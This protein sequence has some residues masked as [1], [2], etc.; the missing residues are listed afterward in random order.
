M[1]VIKNENNTNAKPLS[2]FNTVALM[3]DRQRELEKFSAQLDRYTPPQSIQKAEAFKKTLIKNGPALDKFINILPLPTELQSASSVMLAF[4]GTSAGKRTVYVNY[5]KLA[6]ACI[7]L[8]SVF[9]Y[10]CSSNG[11]E[12]IRKM[13][14]PFDLSFVRVFFD[15]IKHAIYYLS[16]FFINIFPITTQANIEVT[17]NNIMIARS[18]L[19]FGIHAMADLFDAMGRRSSLKQKSK[20]L[21]QDLITTASVV[22]GELMLSL[23]FASFSS[24]FL[25]LFFTGNNY[26]IPKI[27]LDAFD[28]VT[29]LED[30]YIKYE[31]QF[32]GV[33]Y[34]LVCLQIM[35]NPFKGTPSTTPKDMIVN[36]ALAAFQNINYVVLKTAISSFTVSAAHIAGTFAANPLAME[37]YNNMLE[38][39]IR[40]KLEELSEE[41]IKKLQPGNIAIQRLINNALQPPAETLYLE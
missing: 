2:H 12:A 38:E 29:E 37:E 24:K 17:A 6:L 34:L 11:M 16:Y 15:T 35:L 8:I 30:T 9:A 26:S 4:S 22:G 3:R 18:A 21:T 31:D 10:L 19:K 41:N 28:Q 25:S 13:K 36:V 14:D 27:L 32:K 7:Y 40:K 1:V 33:N 39:K 23:L 5:I 20:K